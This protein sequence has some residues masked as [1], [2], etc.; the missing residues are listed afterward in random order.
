MAA[1]ALTSAQSESRETH[2][3]NT[4][5]AR[6]KRQYKPYRCTYIEEAR[7]EDNV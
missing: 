4:G 3:D 7:N 6:S 5:I 1:S 2:V